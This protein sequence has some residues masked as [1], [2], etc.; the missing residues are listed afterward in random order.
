MLFGAIKPEKY[1]SA[2][3]GEEKITT[4]LKIARQEAAEEANETRKAS[5]KIKLQS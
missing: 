5:K 3:G 2:N 4:R 1:S